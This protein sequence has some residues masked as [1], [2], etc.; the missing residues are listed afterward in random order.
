MFNSNN[1]EFHSLPTP[2]HAACDPL[3]VAATFVTFV[4]GS[5]P[6]FSIHR[7]YA[8][9]AAKGDGGELGMRF[10]FEGDGGE[11][12][13]IFFF[14][15]FASVW[16]DGEPMPRQRIATPMIANSVSGY[17]EMIRAT[18]QLVLMGDDLAGRITH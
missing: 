3:C 16:P 9:V 4:S 15:G 11:T 1:P 18:L 12:G 6:I 13:M 17:A 5:G 8:P 7:L 14:S 10:L 2:R